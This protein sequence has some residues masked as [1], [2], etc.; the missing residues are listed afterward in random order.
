V[1]LF[2]HEG[3]AVAMTELNAEAYGPLLQ[4]TGGFDALLLILVVSLLPAV[5]EELAFRKGIQGLLADRLPAA[6][7]IIVSA[8]VFSAFHLD[9]LGLPTRLFL[10]ISLGLVYHLTGSLW[11][12][13]FVHAANNSLVIIGMLAFEG[14][15]GLTEDPIA[16]TRDLSVLALAVGGLCALVPWLGGV[17]LLCSGTPLGE[18]HASAANES[19]ST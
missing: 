7:A 4:T 6:V 16:A 18:P 3:F 8:A 2:V 9:P 11:A 19:P 17:A 12:A 15:A 5:C 14:A 1:L 10:G 13:G